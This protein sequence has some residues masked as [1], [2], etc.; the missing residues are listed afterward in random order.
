MSLT[1]C[2]AGAE[3]GGV[4]QRR[5]VFVIFEGFQS[6][7]LAGPWE[8]F[9]QAGRRSGGDACEGVAREAGVGGSGSALGGGGGVDMAREDAALT[10]WIAAAGAAARRVT[11]VC[12]GVFLLAAAGLVTGRRVTTHWSRA[13]PLG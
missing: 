13:A 6:L 4:Q 9:A 5:V 7:D 10:G 3:P 12:S 1:P 8:V 11:S 2:G